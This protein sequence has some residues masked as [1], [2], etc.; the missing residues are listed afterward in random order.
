MGGARPL[1]EVL[2]DEG[3]NPRFV[4]VA[5]ET[6]TTYVTVDAAGRSVLVDEPGAPV[7]E[8]DVQALLALPGTSL[9]SSVGWVAICGSPPLGIR[10]DG[11]AALV[12]ANHAA[13][14]PCLVDMGGAAAAA[15]LA[16][17]P[18]GVKVSRDEADSVADARAGDAFTAGFIVAC[19]TGRSTVE[20]LAFAAGAGTAN[21]ETRGAGLLE[22]HAR[23]SWSARCES[24]DSLDRRSAH[25]WKPTTIC[26]R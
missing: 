17:H 26:G 20:A 21:A 24:D 22:W 16:A 9:L 19:D 11:H 25:A 5:G 13:G 8:D 15:A 2:D 4:S 18:G 10:L 3:L 14:R 12:G 6:R 7:A 1:V 23:P